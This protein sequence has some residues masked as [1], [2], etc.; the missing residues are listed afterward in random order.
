MVGT[1]CVG[2]LE[3][4][5]YFKTRLG[6][7][8]QCRPLLNCE[9]DLEPLVSRLELIPQLFCSKGAFA[10]A[11]GNRT[12]YISTRFQIWLASRSTIAGLGVR[13]A[14]ITALVG[15]VI[16]VRKPR[17][18]LRKSPTRKAAGAFS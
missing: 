13:A 11:Q 2:N 7:G 10:Q 9:K 6:F 14:L 15:P 4:G 16:P 5:G 17:K 12:P 3:L 18:Y 1:G 8:G